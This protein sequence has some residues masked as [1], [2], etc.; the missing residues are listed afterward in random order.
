MRVSKQGL[1]K[2]G[3]SP[4]APSLPLRRCAAALGPFRTRTRWATETRVAAVPEMSSALDAGIE[5]KGQGPRSAG[6]SRFPNT[7]S[8]RSCH[9][10]AHP[11]GL[12]ALSAL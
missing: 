2:P 4:C 6:L 11:A 12:R 9:A 10:G 3:S 8:A 7:L 1:P 5:A